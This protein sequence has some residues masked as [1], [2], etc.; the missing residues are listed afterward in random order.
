M[1]NTLKEK[2]KCARSV[3]EQDIEK[4]SKFFS[5]LSKGKIELDWD[6]KKS[7]KKSKI[8]TLTSRINNFS[9]IQFL[10]DTLQ[11]L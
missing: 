5:D 10:R 1:Q 11:Y 4:T 2:N 9:N 8:Y 3:L 6:I 7:G